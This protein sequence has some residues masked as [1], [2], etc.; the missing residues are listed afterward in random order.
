MNKINKL[1]YLAIGLLVLD[2]LTKWLIEPV[3]NF[4]FYFFSVNQCWLVVIM[5]AV[6]VL[7]L[8][9]F[10]KSRNGTLLLIIL[11]GA[12]I[13]LTEYILAMLLIG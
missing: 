1:S 5:G 3:E 12:S 6:L 9:L 2:R 7:L 4:K 13:F 10:L 11:G 8:L